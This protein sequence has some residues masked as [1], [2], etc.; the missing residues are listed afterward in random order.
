MGLF[1]QIESGALGAA[2]AAAPAL[3]SK[4]LQQTSF[5]SLQGLVDHLRQAGLDRQ[6]Q[7]WLGDGA[8]LPVSTEQLRAALGDEHVRKLAQQFGLPIDK[9]L[10]LM[11]Q[12]LPQVVDKASPNGK[13]EEPAAS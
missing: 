6:V 1:D 13:I 12:H 2:A 11:S 8:N 3:L 4:A 10:E 7:S 5:G 9:V